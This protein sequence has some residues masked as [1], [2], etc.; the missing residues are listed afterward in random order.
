[1][2]PQVHA[3]QIVQFYAPGQQVVSLCSG[4]GKILFG[5]AVALVK[6]VFI[7]HPNA[8]EHG[9]GLPLRYTVTVFNAFDPAGVVNEGVFVPNPCVFCYRPGDFD[10]VVVVRRR[11][12]HW[13]CNG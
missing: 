10:G 11:P 9:I 5:P 8:S 4:P 6:S 1:M 2:A 12:G 13:A 3:I 7:I